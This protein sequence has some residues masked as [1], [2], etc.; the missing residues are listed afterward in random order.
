MAAHR[1]RSPAANSRHTRCLIISPLRPSH[2]S[3]RI[4]RRREQ[5]RG[6]HADSVVDGDGGLRCT[7]PAW[8][9]GAPMSPLTWADEGLSSAPG[10]G[11]LAGFQRAC[12][13]GASGWAHPTRG[14]QQIQA[15]G[16]GGRPLA[17]APWSLPGA[18]V[19][20]R[21][22]ASVGV[23]AIIGSAAAAVMRWR[24]QAPR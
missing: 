13:I 20:A 16:G 3:T 14:V 17:A 9:R 24:R 1:L 10:S 4:R 11:V 5:P 7:T 15:V 23:A 6:S 21:A 18:A 19:I 12:E 22:G 2:F 8:R